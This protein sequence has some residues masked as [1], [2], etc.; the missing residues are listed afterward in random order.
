MQKADR[1]RKLA[2]QILRGG[3]GNAERRKR[4]A[5]RKS[6]KNRK[7]TPWATA[8]GNRKWG[9]QG[10]KTLRLRVGRAVFIR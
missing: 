10:R 7:G 6:S 2:P 1:K 3:G 9:T 5:L 4:A 8:L